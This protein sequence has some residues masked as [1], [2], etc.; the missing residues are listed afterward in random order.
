MSAF[1]HTLD[2]F[3]WKNSSSRYPCGSSSPNP[4]TARDMIVSWSMTT[5]QVWLFLKDLWF[6]IPMEVCECS[7]F[8]HPVQSAGSPPNHRLLW[9]GS[10]SSLF[11]NID[12]FNVCHRCWV[13]ERNA[14]KEKVKSYGCLETWKFSALTSAGDRFLFPERRSLFW[15]RE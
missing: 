1:L 13:K 11:P 9:V 15:F 5:P 4:P 14:I 2:I 8:T 7:I 10:Q 6:T 12:T 3:K